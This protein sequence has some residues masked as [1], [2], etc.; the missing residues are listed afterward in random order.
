MSSVDGPVYDLLQ[1][2]A[3]WLKVLCMQNAVNH[4]LSFRG[5]AAAWTGNCKFFGQ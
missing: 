4:D 3:G 2:F 1:R 5:H